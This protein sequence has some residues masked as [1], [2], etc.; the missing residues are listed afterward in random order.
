MLLVLP[1]A[2]MT[3][4]WWMFDGLPG[5]GFSSHGPALLALLERAAL[6]GRIP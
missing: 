1:C 6:G 2:L 4:L 5:E 3:L